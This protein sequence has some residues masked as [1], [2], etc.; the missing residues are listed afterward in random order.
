MQFIAVPSLV[1]IVCLGA[2]ALQDRSLLTKAGDELLDCKALQVE[3]DF[4]VNLGED[5]PARRRHIKALQE[6]NQCLSKPKVSVSFGF[7]KSFN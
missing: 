5:A 3:M 4:A 7:S 6:K 2:C 1:I